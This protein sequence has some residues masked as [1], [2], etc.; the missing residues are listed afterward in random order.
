MSPTT[1]HWAGRPVLVTGA[2]GFIGS[3]LTETLVSR[4]AR[5]TAVVRRVSAGQV[6]NRLRNLPAAAVDALE[7]VVHVDLAGPSAVDV[8]S[9]V[10]ADTWFHLAADAYVPASLDQPADVVRTNVMS[11]LNVLQAAQARQPAHLVV[12]SSSEVYGSQQ[13]AIT[14]GHPLEPAT[15]YAASKAAC[16]R[17][18]WSWHHTYGLPLTIV[19]PFNC[20]GPRHVY[21]AVPLFLAKALRGEPI[22]I[23]GSGEQTR[24][25]TFVT[26]TVAGFLALAELPAAGEAYNIGTGTDHRVLD[27]ARAIVELTG[28]RSDLVHGPARA[29]EVRKLQADPAKLTRATGWR[30]EYDLVKGLAANLEW[31]REHVE[32]V[33]PTRS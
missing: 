16:D 20:Y 13:E 19:R 24:D 18:A 5:V 30:A 14:E 21:D 2:D 3:H 1:T 26:D 22:T 31:M 28:S 7:R 4:G 27:V 25:L 29:G 11:T 32:T 23:N 6:T 33:W 9:R 10:E 17:L 15:P 12:T 8:L